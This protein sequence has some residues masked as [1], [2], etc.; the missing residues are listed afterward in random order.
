MFA[1]VFLGATFRQK[2]YTAVEI[3]IELSVYATVY[4]MESSNISFIHIGFMVCLFLFALTHLDG[5]TVVQGGPL[6]ASQLRLV[7]PAMSGYSTV[8]M[9][10]PCA[11][12][13]TPALL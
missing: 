7:F 10:E 3:E 8:V 6:P 4:Y 1:H 9:L 2:I 12:H 5:R 13:I 11:V